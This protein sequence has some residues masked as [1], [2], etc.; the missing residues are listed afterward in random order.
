MSVFTHETLRE[1]LMGFSWNLT[2]GRWLNFWAHSG[3][4]EVEHWRTLC[5]ETCRA[6]PQRGH[7]SCAGQW[8]T[9]HALYVLQ[10]RERT[11][12]NCCALQALPNLL[13]VN[14]DVYIIN[15]H[16]NLKGLTWWIHRHAHTHTEWRVSSS[17]LSADT[18]QWRSCLSSKLSSGFRIEERA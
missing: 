8:N 4:V 2:L 11:C 18:L 12:Q 14:S 17:T 5:V 1:P 3:C 7:R 16:C 6:W 13:N 15:Y 9:S 10:R